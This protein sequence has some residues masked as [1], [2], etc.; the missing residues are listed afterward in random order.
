MKKRALFMF[1]ILLFCLELALPILATEKNVIP[2]IKITWLS[3]GG[4][5]G[6]YNRDLNWLVVGDV[7]IID[8]T[9]NK[10]IEEYDYVSNFSEGLAFVA[11][12]DANGNGKY[13]FIDKN[14]TVVI[15]LEYDYVNCF[16][17]A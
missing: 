15:P 5:P 2:E 12:R 17:R 3:G 9:T 7:G 6:L 16:L 8:L 14:G 10:K 4:K 13:G 11:K 1:L